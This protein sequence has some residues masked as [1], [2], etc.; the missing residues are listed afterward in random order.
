M[1]PFFACDLSGIPDIAVGAYG[2]DATTTESG[3]KRGAVYILFLNRNGSI[4]DEN[5]I[6]FTANT[7]SEPDYHFGISL[8]SIGDLDNEY[9]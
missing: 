1:S 5:I 6:E 9:F 3:A 4:K 7:G 8:A 2:H